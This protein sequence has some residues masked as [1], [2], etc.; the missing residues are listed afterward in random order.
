MNEDILKGKWNQL[1]GEVKRKWGMLTDDELDRIA[2]ERDKMVGVIQERYGRTRD[3]AERE[4]DDF[5][6]TH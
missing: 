2:G 3:E 5:F 6:R 4:V 1:K